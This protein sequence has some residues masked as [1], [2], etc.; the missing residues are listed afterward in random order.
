MFTMTNILG[1]ILGIY[2]IFLERV[3]HLIFWSGQ[4]LLQLYNNIPYIQELYAITCW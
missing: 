2:F 4:G 1:Y 3:E